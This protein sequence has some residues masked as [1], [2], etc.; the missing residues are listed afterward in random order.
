MEGTLNEDL[1]TQN[2]SEDKDEGMVLQE[3]RNSLL[4]QAHFYKEENAKMEDILKKLQL[5][6]THFTPYIDTHIEKLTSLQEKYDT[7]SCNAESIGLS[8]T[9]RLRKQNNYLAKIKSCIKMYHNLIEKLSKEIKT[10]KGELQKS[11]K[12]L[13]SITTVSSDE[14]KTLLVKIDRYEKELLKFEKKYPWLS[15]RQ[16]NLLNISKETDLLNNLRITKDKLIEE[17]QVY[18]GLKPDLNK[19]AQQLADIEKEYESTMTELY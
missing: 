13:T 18:H 10:V 9:D 12:K 4:K 1:S 17:L 8:H 14:V 2:L 5:L 11:E 16:Y 15:D 7:K 3:L 19:A 6:P